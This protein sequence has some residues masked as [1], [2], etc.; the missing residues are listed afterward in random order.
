[1][2]MDVCMMIDPPMGNSVVDYTGSA[3]FVSRLI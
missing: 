3:I 2:A 1:M